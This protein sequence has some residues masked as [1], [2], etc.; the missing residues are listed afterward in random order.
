M[1]VQRIKIWSQKP[2]QAIK[3][4][5]ACIKIGSACIKIGSRVKVI[6]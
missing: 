5:N 1:S 3:I 2:S 6:R 4:G